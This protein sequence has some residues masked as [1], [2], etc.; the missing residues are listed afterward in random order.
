MVIIPFLLHH[1]FPPCFH[2]DFATHVTTINHQVLAG[3]SV[4]QFF[5]ELGADVIKAVKCW[6]SPGKMLG[7]GWTAGKRL[8]KYAGKS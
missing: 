1:Q 7:A 6:V 5:A 8:V 3:P 2:H 4:G